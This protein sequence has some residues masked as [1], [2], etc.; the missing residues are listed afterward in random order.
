MGRISAAVLVI[1]IALLVVASACDEDDAV[2]PA[3]DVDDNDGGLPAVTSE[4]SIEGVIFLET[5]EGMRLVSAGTGP[6]GCNKNFDPGC[7]EEDAELDLAFLP[8]F[9]IDTTEVPW[10]AYRT[11]VDAGSCPANE[12][13]P[14]V[15]D[16]LD[17]RPAVCLNVAQAEA[18]CT[19]AGKRLPN[20]I[21]W[22]RAAS[23]ISGRRFP[24]GDT[25]CDECLNWVQDTDDGAVDGFAQVAPVDEFPDGA[26][27]FGTLNMAGNVWEFT[28][29]PASPD[30]GDGDGD[31]KA[32]DGTDD[33]DEDAPVAYIRGGG[34][35]IPGIVEEADLPQDYYRTTRRYG[36]TADIA[37][38]A[39]ADYIGFRCAL[40]AEDSR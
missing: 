15:E 6:Y 10:S 31:A 16:D 27:P 34:F 18:Y 39:M 36:V 40:D 22:E 30:D 23:G 20:D 38:S 32:D 37:E 4:S 13:L 29:P 9:F 21:E 3:R 26:G 33:E 1:L 28:H 8:S 2:L 14:A 19:F 12:C 17:D 7:G 11:C 24:W 5:R 35:E 25:W